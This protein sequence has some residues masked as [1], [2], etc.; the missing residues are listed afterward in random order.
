MSKATNNTTPSTTTKQSL[1]KNKAAIAAKQMLVSDAL[2]P[3]ALDEEVSNKAATDEIQTAS[4]G[5]ATSGVVLAQA[6]VIPSIDGAK[7]TT[8]STPT[9]GNPVADAA[10]TSPLMWGLLGLGGLLGLAGAG[11]GGSGGGGGGGIAPSLSAFVID[12]YLMG[13]TVKR[14]N[15]TGNTVLTDENGRFTG[16]TGDGAIIVTGGKDKSTGQDFTG[17]LTAPAG[18]TVV[19]PITTLIQALVVSGGTNVQSA[20]TEIL[21][22]LGLPANFNVL[23]ADPI[24]LANSGNAEA[25]AV[26]KAGVMVATALQVISGGDETQFAAAANALARM[27]DAAPVGTLAG[28]DLLISLLDDV[29]ASVNP[30]T[31]NADL[32]LL[33]QAL[34]E[35]NDLTTVS[36][37]A[38]SQASV[39]NQTLELESTGSAI[40]LT[41]AANA[42]AKT[43]SFGGSASGPVTIDIDTNGT[44]S[45]SRAGI[46]STTTV[47]NF[48]DQSGFYTVDVAAS[49]R[50]IVNVAGG[51]LTDDV[52]SI[53][54]LNTAQIT[55]SGQMGGGQDS[56]YIKI[57]DE[58]NNSRVLTINTQALSGIEHL[59]FDFADKNDLV[60]LTAD[61][62]LA[63]IST[64]EVKK[65]TADL[66]AVSIPEGTVFVVNSGLTMTLTQLLASES[67]ASVTGLGRLTIL[68]NSAADL[69]GKDLSSLNLIGFGTDEVGYVEIKT[70]AGTMLYT[71]NPDASAYTLNTAAKTAVEAIQGGSLPSIPALVDLVD[72][73]QSQITSNGANIASLVSDAAAHG[74]TPTTASIAGIQAA[75]TA[76]NSIYATDS[77]VAD[78]LLSQFNTLTTNYGT[79]IINAIDALKGGTLNTSYDTLVEIGTVVAA[80]KSVSDKLDGSVGTSGSLLKAVADVTTA[81]GTAISDAIAALRVT[82]NDGQTTYQDFADVATKLGA[83]QTAIDGLDSIYATDSAVADSLLSQFNTLTTNKR[84]FSG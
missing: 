9:P 69:A 81:Y 15:G 39:L 56:V 35:I 8:S 84:P 64:I 20:P 66:H 46:T 31:S 42:S 77:A 79:A 16:L 57:A 38:G 11:G 28:T 2:M 25:L 4:D 14:A 48:A 82:L 6:N 75:L 5:I 49:T 76:L 37:V 50:L 72:V 17:T 43:V 41:V 68:V 30:S 78:S 21:A 23:S 52:L 53:S 65:G 26:V 83:L 63:N 22:K 19:T 47:A 40:T 71:T 80:L 24:A 58:T 59:A 62:Y 55:L 13:S 70:V 1:P 60:V 3:A 7:S 73:L 74:G 34:G 54:A 45:F 36:A 33:T 44:A 18:S 32:A 29:V 51:E 27:L 10:G 61:S 67:I 12:G